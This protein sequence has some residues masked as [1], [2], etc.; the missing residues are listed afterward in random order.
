MSWHSCCCAWPPAGRCTARPL[1]PRRWTAPSQL[2]AVPAPRQS[3]WEPQHSEP[4]GSPHEPP[5]DA[6]REDGFNHKGPFCL[7]PLENSSGC[8]IKQKCAQL[9]TPGQEGDSGE[10]CP[11]VQV[12]TERGRSDQGGWWQQ[13][14]T[15]LQQHTFGNKCGQIHIDYLPIDHPRT[16]Q[17]R[18]HPKKCSK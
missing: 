9:D 7:Q 16:S 3:P 13:G 6:R 1:D 4:S 15:R 18:L 5:T 17:L 8:N 11:V 2:P 12:S 14:R 10:T